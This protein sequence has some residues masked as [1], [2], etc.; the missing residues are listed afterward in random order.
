MGIRT[1]V[2]HS[3]VVLTVFACLA[4][5]GCGGKKGS[6]SRCSNNNECE[7]GECAQYT[8]RDGTSFLLCSGQQT[9]DVP[10]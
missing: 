1:A 8:T 2:L 6:C 5:A 7:S 10:R 4:I 3:I 9:C